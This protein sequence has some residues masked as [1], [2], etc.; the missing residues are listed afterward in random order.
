MCV[1][2]VARAG[3]VVD[4]NFV[5][6]SDNVAPRDPDINT[7]THRQYN[8][9]NRVLFDGSASLG[10][11]IYGGFQA[12]NSVTVKLAEFVI[13][14]TDGFLALTS[15]FAKETGSFQNKNG[16]MLWKTAD[17]V[18]GNHAFDSS[19]DSSFSISTGGTKH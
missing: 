19:A 6:T 2:L 10:Q 14:N 16:V 17:F 4:L 1:A 7:L 13:N 3:L 8:Y 11:K 15:L 12:T 5:G 18:S 9:D